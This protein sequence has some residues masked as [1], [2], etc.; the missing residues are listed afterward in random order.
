MEL[1]FK[2]AIVNGQQ[3]SFEATTGK[4]L[5]TSKN[6]ETVVQSSVSGGGGRLSEGSGR[7]RP[8]EVSVSSTTIVHDQLFLE[9]AQGREH[10]FQLQGFDVACREGHELSLVFAL[11]AGATQG[12]YVAVINHSTRQKFYNEAVLHRLSKPSA[13]LYAVVCFLLIGFVFKFIPENASKSGA[14]LVL[15]VAPIVAIGKFNQRVAAGKRA[16]KEAV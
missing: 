8:V 3:F 1:S 14:W 7:I 5:N 15:L 11:R 12:P 16:F 13:A 2:T 10:A 6:L 4:V 9:D